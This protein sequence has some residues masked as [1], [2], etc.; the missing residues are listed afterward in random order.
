VLYSYI[1]LHTNEQLLGKI[2]AVHAVSGTISY[3]ILCKIY[4]VMYSSLHK[5]KI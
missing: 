2:P 5:L 4:D 3:P 1:H